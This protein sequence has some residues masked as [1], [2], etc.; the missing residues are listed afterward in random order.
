MK[1]ILTDHEILTEM[2]NRYHDTFRSYATKEPD[3][4]AWIRVPDD[5]QKVAKEVG[6]YKSKVFG[7]LY[8]HFNKKYSNR[9]EN[10]DRISFYTSQKIDG[11]SVDSPLLASVSADLESED[12]KYQLFLSIAISALS[13]SFNA[14]TLSVL[15]E[16]VCE[17]TKRFLPAHLT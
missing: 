15:P 11:M 16:T 7:Q 3:K 6:V 13:F 17:F 10:R 2:I 1:K 5:T 4:I 12:L 14:L 8:Y 9:D